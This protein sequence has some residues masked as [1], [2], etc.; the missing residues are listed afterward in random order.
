MI[1]FEMDIIETEGIS[2]FFQDF[3]T[4]FK[5]E[6]ADFERGFWLTRLGSI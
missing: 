4:S 2:D 6:V 5:V 3:T 1:R